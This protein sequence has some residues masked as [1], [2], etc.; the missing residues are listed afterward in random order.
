MPGWNEEDYSRQ[1]RKAA[2]NFDLNMQLFSSL[3]T[4]AFSSYISAQIQKHRFIRC[5]NLLNLRSV[6]GVYMLVL[7]EF[8]QVYIGQSSDIYKRIRSHWTKKKSL[9]RLIFGKVWNSILCIDSFGALDT[10]R[11]YYIKANSTFALEEQIVSD[12]NPVYTLNRTSGGIGSSCTYTDTEAT[13]VVAVLANRRTKDLLPFL[14]LPE[15]LD[16]VSNNELIEYISRHPVFA[17]WFSLQR[18]E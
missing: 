4:A 17:R 7:D 11:V 14:T 10:T 8:K 16:V 18:G 1:R 13:A 9:E 5:D 15:L 3:D 6:S 2:L 12:F